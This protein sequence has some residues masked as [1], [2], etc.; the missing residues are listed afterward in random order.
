MKKKKIAL[1]CLFII[2]LSSIAFFFG[3]HNYFSIENIQIYHKT[4]KDFVTIHPHITPLL[5]ILIL[6]IITALSFP[7]VLFMSF[8]GGYLFSQ[9]YSTLY[10]VVASTL[11]SSIFFMAAD[12]LLRD[13]VMK[14]AT[15]F[16]D[17]MKKG[18][19]KNAAHYLLFLRLIP[20]FPFWIVNVAA[21]FFRVPLKTFIWTTLIGIIPEI[22]IITLAGSGLET[23]LENQ[24]PL[25]TSAIFNTQVKIALFGLAI[26]ALVPVLFR[27]YKRPY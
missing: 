2:F 13:P 22:F 4:I 3:F 25:T 8:I 26:L 1:C 18:F 9:P 5:F 17:E 10:A 14:K 6:V 7:G 24:N 19:L 27:K 12:F 16:L 20:L 15:L 21:I 23:L 11:G